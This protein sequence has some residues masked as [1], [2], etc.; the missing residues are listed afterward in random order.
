MANAEND[1]KLDWPPKPDWGTIDAK[2]FRKQGDGYPD[3]VP[4]EAAGAPQPEIRESAA[5]AAPSAEPVGTSG[6]AAGVVQRSEHHQ[7]PETTAGIAT[8]PSADLPDPTNL[9]A[10]LK[11]IDT[12]IAANKDDDQ[13]V[14]YMVSIRSQVVAYNNGN[15]PPGKPGANPQDELKKVQARNYSSR[16]ER[17]VVSGASKLKEL[18]V[19]PG[20]WHT[21]VDLYVNKLVNERLYFRITADMRKA[22]TQAT[23]ERDDISVSIQKYLAENGETNKQL[24]AKRQELKGNKDRLDEEERQKRDALRSYGTYLAQGETLKQNAAEFAGN[25][26]ENMI[27]ELDHKDQELVAEVEELQDTLLENSAD[28]KSLSYDRQRLSENVTSMRLVL[29]ALEFAKKRTETRQKYSPRSRNGVSYAD[30]LGSLAEDA[31]GFLGYLRANNQ[32]STKGRQEGPHLSDIVRPAL[33]SA[34]PQA[35]ESRDY[36]AERLRAREERHSR[37]IERDRQVASMYQAQA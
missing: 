34:L 25:V 19:L 17:S 13:L 5:P 20:V 36:D 10:L 16:L 23:A 9:D 4:S 33:S 26:A 37:L 3:D 27:T 7:E 1:A 8:D 29:R 30:A 12:T 2:W 22:V 21:A 32:L 11:R 24:A 28:M 31:A 15:A 14:A 18:G 6:A 35:T